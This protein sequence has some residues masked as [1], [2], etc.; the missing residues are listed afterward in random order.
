MKK[1]LLSSALILGVTFAA[2]SQT[3]IGIVAGPSFAKLKTSG[4]G[5]SGT[6]STSTLTSFHAGFVIDAPLTDNVYFQPRILLS[7]KGGKLKAKAEGLKGTSTSNPFYIEVPFN[8]LYKAPAGS[9][10][11][12][13]GL[14]PYAGI[15]V[16]GKVKT[17]FVSGSQKISK[18]ETIK[19]G[20]G[21]ND[22]FKRFDFGLNFLLGYEFD[23][24]FFINGNYSLGLANAAP[25]TSNDVTA[26][27]QYFGISIGYLFGG[28]GKSSY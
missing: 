23:G 20:S 21:K 25:N 14:G 16:F 4:S 27:L 9:G 3:R 24:G 10:R 12:F 28:N 7:G 1:I 6:C 18:D 11:L 22:D 13:L 8:F 15:G 2:F 26:H 17:D 5:L 19:F